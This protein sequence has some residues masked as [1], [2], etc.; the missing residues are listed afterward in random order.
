MMVIDVCKRLD[1]SLKRMCTVVGETAISFTK[2]GIE[3]LKLK[4]RQ[5]W[6]NKLFNIQGVNNGEKQGV[7]E[8]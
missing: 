2:L 8:L 5:R 3:L 6:Y 4:R 7:F 1:N